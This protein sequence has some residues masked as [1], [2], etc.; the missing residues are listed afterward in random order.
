MLVLKKKL[1]SS[2]GIAIRQTLPGHVMT[3]SCSKSGNPIKDALS[4]FNIPEPVTTLENE[5]KVF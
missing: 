4:S 2:L 5:A 3:S 1:A